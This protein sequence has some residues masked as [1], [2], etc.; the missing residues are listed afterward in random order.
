MD[1]NEL[2]ISSEA[3]QRHHVLQSILGWQDVCV[4]PLKPQV[5]L[6]ELSHKELVDWEFW[7]V[8]PGYKG[9]D[10]ETFM[11]HT[12]QVRNSVTTLQGLKKVLGDIVHDDFYAELESGLRRASM[13]MRLSPYILSLINWNDLYRCPLRRQFV[14]LGSKVEEDH[15]KLS[16]DTLHEQDDAPTPGITHR[17]FDRVL[18]L[19]LNTCPVY[20]RFCT[21]SYAIGLDTNTISKV[22]LGINYE[23][24]KLAFSYIASRPEVEDVVVSGGDIYNLRPKQIEAIGMILLDMPNIRRIR[25]AT[26]G[27][28]VMPQK[29][30]THF[31]WIDAIA[32]VGEKGRQ[33]HKE[34]AIHTHFNHPREIT[35]ISKRAADLLF[36]RG[37]KV[38]NQ[39]VLLRGVNDNEDTMITLIR[40][41][42]YINI[43]PYYVYLCDMV[44]GI[45]DLRTSV[46]TAE[47]LEKYV[48]G[49]TAGFNTPTFVCDAPQGG[50]KRSI[51]SY[52]FYDRENGIAAYAAPSVKKGEIFLYFD[53]LHS[54]SPAARARWGNRQDQDRMIGKVLE[55]VKTSTVFSMYH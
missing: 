46:G 29:V 41:L 13:A 5:S 48:R 45:E 24:W 1:A 36:E 22:Y 30:L 38:R 49:T 25:F 51:Y 21:R 44:K 40:R 34:V 27:L 23:R 55:T 2:N 47:R 50:G 35:W 28:A 10:Q 14:P 8:I 33:L 17:Y 52:E 19:P 26:K 32:K 31:D 16:L 3:E 4:Q 53:P 7:R 39:S 9:I 12:W 11:D 54:L 37:I 20:C 42:S 18:F 43:Q 6:E 15:P